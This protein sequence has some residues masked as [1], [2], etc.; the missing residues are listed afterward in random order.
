MTKKSSKK[1]V[2]EDING[3]TG[4]V[5]VEKLFFRPSVY[6]VLIEGDK[7]LLS[8][9]WDGY[10]F[11]GGGMEIGETIKD[12][13][14]REFWE[15]IGLEVEVGDVILAD[16]SFFK[17]PYADKYCN[18]ILVYYLVKRVGGKLSINNCDDN[19][20]KYLG[21]PEWIDLNEVEKIKFYNS[22]DSVKLINKAKRM[23]K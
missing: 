4:E 3:K 21:M 7:I 9:Q 14:K 23:L 18:S 5:V 16:S 22:I 13:L 11:P 17:Y 15:E 6:S 12:A 8:K 20:Q 10:D 19:E 1:V 2:Y